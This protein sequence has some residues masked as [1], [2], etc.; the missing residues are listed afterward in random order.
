[1]R[2]W[3]RTL[4]ARTALAFS[5]MLL[6]G[7]IATVVLFLYF[8]TQPI[9]SSTALYLGQQVQSIATAATHF[10]NKTRAAYI[11][12]LVS[13]G[14]V[15]YLDATRATP[16]GTVARNHFQQTLSD[17]ITRQLGGQVSVRFAFTPAQRIVWVMLP[18]ANHPA[19]LGVLLSESGNAFPRSLLAQMLV[20]A[21]LTLLGSVWFAYRLNRPIKHLVHAAQDIAQGRTDVQLVPSGPRELR[22]LGE[23]F[24]QMVLAIDKLAEDR[25][26]LLA[27]VSHDLRTPLSRLRL[28][29]E[30]VNPDSDPI[31]L[32]GMLQDLTEMDQIIEQFLAYTRQ[33]SEEASVP[34]DLNKLVQQL[35]QRYA[36]QGKTLQLSLAMLPEFMFKPVAMHRLLH[37][38]IDNAWEYGAA[39]VEVATCLSDRWV[40]LCVRDSGPGIP[41]AAIDRVCQPFTRQDVA[42]S[43]ALHAGLGLAIVARI[44]QA[45]HGRV[46]VANR[47]GGG[48][49][50]CVSLPCTVPTP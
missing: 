3:P 13:A 28:A 41:A 2:L 29:L 31:L 1:M 46:R 43:Q 39:P 21:M 9:A 42:R 14:N 24:N 27:G 45:H 40:E 34:A 37:N 25:N 50:V 8:F 47:E 15:R 16:P 33:G 17:E 11:Q 44:A 22:E 18:M 48:L 10:D 5:G 32:A 23:T 4:F 6:L 49:A 36:Q 26:L 20:I 38:L 30:M 19:W 7:Y 12:S 35:A